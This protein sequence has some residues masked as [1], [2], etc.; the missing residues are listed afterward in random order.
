MLLECINCAKL[1][2]FSAAGNVSL[3]ELLGFCDFI[4]IFI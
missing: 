1:L 3:A 2:Y 4:F